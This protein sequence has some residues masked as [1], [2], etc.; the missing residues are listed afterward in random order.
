MA[1]HQQNY[2]A[3]SAPIIA[4]G[5]VIAGIGGGDSGVRGF[6]SAYDAETG[7]Q[8]WRFWIISSAGRAWIGNL[9][10]Q[11]PHAPGRGYLVHRIVRP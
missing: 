9:E 4:G 6:L 1:D 5:L 10:G 8:A 7:K 2:F 3:T 11:Y